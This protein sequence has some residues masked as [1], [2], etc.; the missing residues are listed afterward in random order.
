LRQE[1]K[2]GNR[3]ILSRDLQQALSRVLAAGQQAILFLNR[4]GTATFVMCRDCGHV[5]TCEHCDVPLTYHV[6]AGTS[7]AHPL[8]VCHHCSRRQPS[9][10]RCPECHSRRIR[11]L[12]TGT[13]KIAELV[14]TLWPAARVLRWDR[15]V[16]GPKGSHDAILTRF[17]ERKADVMVGTQMIAKGLDLPMVTLVGVISADVGLYLPDFR[18][19]ERSFQLLTQVAGRAGRSLLGG[20]VIIQSYRPEHYVIQ[21]ARRHDY[22]DFYRQELGF[23]RELGYPPFRRLAKLVFVHGNQGRAQAE[24]E[25]LGRGLRFLIHQHNLANVDLIGPAP[26]FFGRESG[27]YRWQIVVRAPDPAAFLR[28]ASIPQGWRIDVDPVSVL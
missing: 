17:V 26:C 20:R 13:E 28:N 7:Q 18:A 6:Q 24:A 14:Q 3:S 25:A 1:L 15:D 27:K 12:G 8:L 5:L 19:A 23:R 4:R 10:E 9:P 22:F 16:T 21:A 11:Y 2:A